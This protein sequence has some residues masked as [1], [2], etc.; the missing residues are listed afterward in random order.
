[1][2]HKLLIICM[3]ILIGVATSWHL[4]LCKAEADCTR[5]NGCC[6]T[7]IA[8]GDNCVI[9]SVSADNFCRTTDTNW[10]GN[11]IC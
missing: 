8:Y 7:T 4:C 10:M 5:A 6:M 9:S 11:N 1:M 2:K 3:S